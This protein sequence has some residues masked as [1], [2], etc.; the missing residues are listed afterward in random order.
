MYTQIKGF[1]PLF[2]QAVVNQNQIN[3]NLAH[4]NATDA[5][6][7]ALFTGLEGDKAEALKTIKY[8]EK[9]GNGESINR[10]RL[11]YKHTGL[12]VIKTINDNYVRLG[13]VSSGL[14]INSEENEGCNCA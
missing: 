9:L 7:L 4:L 11:G 8:S 13:K 2:E 1:V 12:G 10:E 6:T 3:A 14:I 5:V